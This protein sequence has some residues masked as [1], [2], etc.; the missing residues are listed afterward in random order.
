MVVVQ[1]TKKGE[2][3]WTDSLRLFHFWC[4]K[5]LPLV[6][7]DSLS[8]Y[9]V[10][11]KLTKHLNE[12]T[13]L[14]NEIGDELERYEGVTDNR[15]DTLETWRTEVDTWRA[16]IDEWKEDVNTW[17]E[18]T[19]AWKQS[20]ENHLT[21]HDNWISYATG[22]INDTIMPFIED[23]TTRV[24]NI[25]NRLS[26]AEDDIDA[27]EDRMDTA[28]DDIDTLQSDVTGLDSR[29]DDAETALNSE[30]T[31]LGTVNYDS[32][33]DRAYITLNTSTSCDKLQ[34]LV[35]FEAKSDISRL[36]RKPVFYLTFGSD[37]ITHFENESYPVDS[38]IYFQDLNADVFSYMKQGSNDV[39]LDGLAIVMNDYN[40]LKTVKSGVTYRAFYIGNGLYYSFENVGTDIE[41]RLSGAEDDIDSLEGRITTA[42][43]DI[44]DLDDRIVI[45]SG[46]VY[47]D[48]D[49]SI[50][51]LDLDNSKNK[52][53]LNSKINN[54]NYLQTAVSYHT[55]FIFTFV[56][57]GYNYEDLVISYNGTPLQYNSQN[58]YIDIGAPGSASVWYKDFRSVNADLYV[59]YT[60]PGN[61][62]RIDRLI[63]ND[64]LNLPIP[65]TTYD[66]GKVV[67]YNDTLKN[68]ELITPSG[69]STHNY[70]TT[71]QVV[72]KWINNANVYEKVFE[73]N[74]VSP[75]NGLFTLLNNTEYANS[76]IKKIISFDMW[77][78]YGGQY[79]KAWSNSWGSTASP[80]VN[81]TTFIGLA[82]N[83][84]IGL[85]VQVGALTGIMSPFSGFA[86]IRYTKS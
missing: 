29:L 41:N 63:G 72:G 17:I 48:S 18:Q 22:L 56:T 51:K 86:I 55:I 13:T 36:V 24:G 30:Y 69:G 75:A 71:E 34:E 78:S 64:I 58:V 28:E 2:Q 43:N 39:I 40:T 61:A 68:Y 52:D 76:G 6:Y 20:T 74:N 46:T 27:L 47:F 81:D 70:S 77:A 54:A 38:R 5:T 3:M 80:G 16:Q 60:K 4:Q 9:E 14:V 31:Y 82:Q 44:I 7:D 83:D 84:A 33:D 42:E 8:Y 49:N 25:E 37:V 50:W 85:Y 79:N 21:A 11:A 67:A 23:M 12:L 65:D 57:S 66:N 53:Y 19:D 26:G 45:I 59:L 35:D 73:F 10:L 62:V 32:T 1:P 15:L